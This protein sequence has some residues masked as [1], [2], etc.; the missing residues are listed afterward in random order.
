MPSGC[1]QS[2]C[3]VVSPNKVSLSGCRSSVRRG[4]KGLFFAWPMRTNERRNGTSGSQILLLTHSTA[5]AS[6]RGS[7]SS[8]TSVDS[9]FDDYALCLAKD[10]TEIPSRFIFPTTTVRHGIDEAEADT[11]SG[12]RCPASP[13]RSDWSPDRV[14]FS[15]PA[16]STL[17][18]S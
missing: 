6:L 17:R 5:T 11:S 16:F 7:V 1:Q 10:C 3:H 15:P 9:D 18:V 12:W 4:A 14:L 13:V 2:L 8:L